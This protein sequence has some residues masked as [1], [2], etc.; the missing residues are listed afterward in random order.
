MTRAVW[1]LADRRTADAAKRKLDRREIGAQAGLGLL[2]A[3][4]A[5]GGLL[6]AVTAAHSGAVSAGDL[7]MFVDAVAAVQGGLATL[8]RDTA[9]CHHALLLLDHYLEVT[10]AGPDLQVRARPRPLPGLRQGIELRNVWFRYSDQHPW[11]LR[12]LDLRIPRGSA[13]ALVGL[14]GA[15]KSTLVKLLCRFYDPTRGQILWDGVDIRDVDAGELRRRIGAVFQDYMSYD[16]SASENI[17]LGDLDALHDRARIEAAA[18][19]AGV[20]DTLAGLPHG[21][22]T[23]LTRLFFMESDKQDPATGVVLSGGQWQRLAIARAFVRDRRELMILD[24]PSSGL[25]AAAEH[26]IHTCLA[27]HR[28][29]RTSLLIS[30][31]LGAVRDADVIVVLRGGRI[32]ERGDHHA[33]LAA[34]G[35]YARLFHLQASRYQA[36]TPAS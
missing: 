27:R 2:A 14:N 10:T 31:R 25:D 18:A 23:L 34:A 28:G 29:G 7:T 4:V 19:R 1:M 8:A 6:W 32:V 22:D 5:G 3:L 26:E 15:G 11:I 12:G 33:L 35:E 13:L 9:R 21:Y 20:H 16:M 24:E 36:D 17:G 30:H